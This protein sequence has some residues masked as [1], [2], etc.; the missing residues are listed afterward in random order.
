MMSNKVTLRE[1]QWDE[2]D[3]PGI[4]KLCRELF[5]NYRTCTVDEFRAVVRHR[6]MDNPW[7]RPDHLM[8][9]VLES[10]TDGLVGFVG[11]IP[12]GMKVGPREV[13]GACGTAFVVTPAA[14]AYSL[15]LYKK[16]TE[17]GDRQLLLDVTSGVVGNKL[18]STLKMGIKKIPVEGLQER[19]LWMIRPEEA[20]RWKLEAPRYRP[21][22]A[23]LA[24][25]PAS[26]GVAV[27]ARMRF[28]PHRRL[29]FPDGGLPVA[30]VKVVTDEFTKLWEDHKAAYGV[31]AIRTREYLQW[32]HLDAPRF[33]GATTLL[34]CRAD[35]RLLGYAAVMERLQ[36][37][38]AAPG[39]YLLTDLFYDR[40]RPDVLA[41]LMNGAF[42]FAKAA[43]GS[44]L[45]VGIMSAEL[46]QALRTQGPYIPPL[47]E[48]WP[49]WYKAPAA[50]LGA[51]CE[52]ESWW[53][54]GSDGDANL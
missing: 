49:Y 38:W 13:I 40:T 46:R 50:E 20:V 1:A 26:W 43:G 6:W 16:F 23:W 52:Q 34:A 24:H 8:G 5:E 15:S 30:P 35:G 14:R 53:P 27:A 31:T 33:M 11:L 4:W 22:G 21:W 44:V 45:E 51:L 10:A 19:F 39:R 28:F 32:R 12:V 42:D 25:A 17:W 48:S 36:S 9:W 3:L 47:A 2:R 7:R 54:S 37:V 41:S 29:R 18:H